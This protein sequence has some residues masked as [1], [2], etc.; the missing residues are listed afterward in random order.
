VSYC[1]FIFCAV[2]TFVSLF[3]YLLF[4]ISKFFKN[5]IYEFFLMSKNLVILTCLIMFYLHFMFP[6]ACVPSSI[7][8]MVYI[9]EMPF[10]HTNSEL[11][12]SLTSTFYES[13]FCCCFLPIDPN[14]KWSLRDTNILLFV[15][16]HVGPFAIYPHI[17]WSPFGHQNFANCPL[18]C[19]AF[20][21]ISPC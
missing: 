8:L 20:G 9:S 5:V 1:F 21:N 4:W 7:T 11:F 12:R 13:S 6:V 14:F 10:F 3:S 17:K 2:F 15:P 18:P 19:W 16:F